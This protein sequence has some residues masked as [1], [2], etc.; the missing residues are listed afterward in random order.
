[1]SHE[2]RT[3]LDDA[4]PLSI[5]GDAGE[6]SL[7]S[8]PPPPPPPS[9]TVLA[10]DR[11]TKRAGLRVAEQWRETLGDEAN[12]TMCDPNVAADAIETLLSGR[13]ELAD[14]PESQHRARWW[15]SLLDAPETQALR[16]RTVASASTA[17]LAAAEIA[18]AWSE[19]V[20]ANPEPKPDPDAPP[21]DGPPGEP[22]D[23]ES[24]RDS[25]A[26]MRSISEA[27]RDATEAAE[28]AESCGAGLGIEGGSADSASVARYARRVR[29]SETLRRIMRMAG[30]FI[31]KAQ[32][33][34]AQRSEHAGMEI[35]GVELSGDLSRALPME[36]AQIAGAVPELEEQALLRFVERRTL[37]YKRIKKE[38]KAMG[39]IVVSVDESG[40]MYGEKVEAAK[41]LALAMASIARAQKRQ[42]ILAGYSGET[43]IRLADP[44]PDGI[45]AWCEAF[46]SGG[47]NCDMPCQSIR[48][49]WPEG[50]FGKQADHIIIS[51]AE[52]WYNNRADKHVMDR[53]LD[54]YKRW[55]KAGNVR[56]F[57]LVIG[58]HKPGPFAT[59]SDGGC[60]SIPELSLD[61]AGIDSILSVGPDSK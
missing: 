61:A 5:E 17:E 34:Q 3:L 48:E 50:A 16:A 44:T 25:I 36:L 32:R 27:L 15:K 14:R 43:R 33:M 40:S 4:E 37:S 53:W 39:P 13:P 21:M 6:H 9:P 56:T 7:D 29:S 55:A 2:I 8:P 52:V 19:Y 23:D 10:T 45:I 35:T 1:M 59:I 41:G 26:R 28:E 24:P 42:F 51:D 12:D 30:R 11:W 22:S 54:D 57:S 49:H 31:A 47:T 18:R 38:P 20:V 60:W 46:L 58:H